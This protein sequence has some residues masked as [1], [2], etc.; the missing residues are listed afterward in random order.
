MEERTKFLG[1][2]NKV[3]LRIALG[4]STSSYCLNGRVD[5]RA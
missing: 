2:L 1:T 4:T 5:M 3:F